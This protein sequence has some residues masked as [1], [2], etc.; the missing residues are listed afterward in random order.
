ME[1]RRLS[2]GDAGRR[3][4]LSRARDLFE[5]L[6]RFPAWLVVLWAWTFVYAVGVLVGRDEESGAAWFLCVIAAGVV[7]GYLA[8]RLRDGWELYGLGWLAL[9][10]GVKLPDLDP[11]AEVLIG[12]P[13][14]V[15]LAWL[16]VDRA[17][18]RV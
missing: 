13:I 4:G 15:A 1:A 14:S 17:R 3:T 16:L 18:A 6:A 12:A 9:F 5:R 11:L 7:A 10:L 2:R 8:A